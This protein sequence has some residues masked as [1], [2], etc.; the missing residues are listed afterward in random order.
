MGT[1]L[2]R[3][4]FEALVWES[5]GREYLC[6]DEIGSAIGALGEAGDG[7][8]AS[9]GDICTNMNEARTGEG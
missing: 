8:G 3:L 5:L 7:W 6:Q 4:W 9:G 2:S 1:V